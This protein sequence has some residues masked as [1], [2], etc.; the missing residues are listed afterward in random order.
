MNLTGTELLIRSNYSVS[1]LSI[2]DKK[3]PSAYLMGKKR[4]DNPGLSYLALVHIG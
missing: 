2:R 3:N 4:I 1:P